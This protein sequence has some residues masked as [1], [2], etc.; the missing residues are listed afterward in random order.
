MKSVNL[1]TS[2]RNA[3]RYTLYAKLIVNKQIYHRIGQIGIISMNNLSCKVVYICCFLVVMAYTNH[4]AADTAQPGNQSESAEKVKKDEPKEAAKAKDIKAVPDPT[5]AGTVNPLLKSQEEI[6]HLPSDSVTLNN[7][8]Q[9]FFK[10][11]DLKEKAVKYRKLVEELKKRVTICEKLA[12][13]AEL[14]SD[15]IDKFIHSQLAKHQEVLEK[16]K[17][18]T[19]KKYNMDKSEN[20]N[21]EK[22]LS[23]VVKQHD[24]YRK[25][26]EYKAKVNEYMRMMEEA[27]AAAEK[28]RKSMDDI[29]H[30]P[31]PD[32]SALF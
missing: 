7:L 29:K 10:S 5:S 2:Y 15:R 27:K 17:A 30:N 26:P 9:L 6:P 24:D 8:K 13:Q 22:F 18:Q 11:R 16:I 14:E 4:C 25:T 19:V 31:V 21:V 12:D 32:P 1:K 3:A 28:R 23:E 20:T